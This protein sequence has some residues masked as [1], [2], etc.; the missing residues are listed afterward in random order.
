V[1]ID[2]K[3][4]SPNLLEHQ[5]LYLYPHWFMMFRSKVIKEETAHE[6]IQRSGGIA[7]CI[8]KL[9]HREAKTCGFAPSDCESVREQAFMTKVR[10]ESTTSKPAYFLRYYQK[11]KLKKAIFKVHGK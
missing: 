1:P 6:G 10:F 4:G 9:L 8:L 2:L 3:S 5:G 7:P 11:K